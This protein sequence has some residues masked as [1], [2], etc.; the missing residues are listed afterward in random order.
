VA[1]PWLLAGVATMQAISLG[2]PLP[3]LVWDFGW[4]VILG[5]GAFA[6]P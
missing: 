5:I 2:D 4:L 3:Q 1:P 6:G